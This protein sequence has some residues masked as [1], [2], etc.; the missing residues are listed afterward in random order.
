MHDKGYH[1]CTLTITK[2]LLEGGLGGVQH[3]PC[4]TQLQQKEGY[5][6]ATAPPDASSPAAA[7][8][9]HTPLTQPQHIARSTSFVFETY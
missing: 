6:T 4:P 3:M 5:T 8:F 7:A 9:L 2:P 1:W